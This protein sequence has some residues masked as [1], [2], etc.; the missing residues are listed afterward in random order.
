MRFALVCSELDAAGINIRNRLLELE[1]FE[2][3]GTFDGNPYFKLKGAEAEVYTLNSEMV[4]REQICEEIKAD[5]FIF[6]SKHKSSSGIPSLSV[7][8]TGNWGVAELGGAS[9]RLSVA[10]AAYLKRALQLI[11]S[12]NQN[13]EYDIVQECTH[14]GPL[15]EKP[16]FFIEIGSD[17]KRWQD[18]EAGGVIAKTVSH[19]I[20]ENVPS[21]RAAIGIGGLHTLTN[22][23]KII[24]NSDYGISHA[25][26]KYMLNHLDY[27]MLEEAFKKSVPKPEAIILDWKGLGSE[28]E[29]VSRLAEDFCYKHGLKLL[30]TSNF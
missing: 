3:R 22:F 28:K 20:R 30:R 24:L 12:L 21:C 29:R 13:P 9:R 16:H 15:V 23:K 19:I 1:K 7:H 4:R 18:E 10:N 17:E 26:P 25:C 2:E 27:E 6:M 11:N 14:H 5:F 8:A